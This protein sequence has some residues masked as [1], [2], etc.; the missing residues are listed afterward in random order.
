MQVNDE[1]RYELCGFVAELVGNE[2]S[3]SL[4]DPVVIHQAQKCVAPEPGW[5][6][7][8]LR[9]VSR[10]DEDFVEWLPRNSKVWI[11]EGQSVWIAGRN[12]YADLGSSK[13]AAYQFDLDKWEIYKR[14]L[15]WTTGSKRDFERFQSRIARSAEEALAQLLFDP[16]EKVAGFVEDVFRVYT[17]LSVQDSL[18][19]FVWEGLFY[20]ETRAHRD[21]SLAARLAVR[22]GFVDSIDAFDVQV[23]HLRE[24]LRLPRL[25]ESDPVASNS[26]L[27]SAASYL[28][29][30]LDAQHT[31]RHAFEL[32]DSVWADQEFNIDLRRLGYSGEGLKSGKLE[33]EV[34]LRQ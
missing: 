9:R 29:A 14:G 21:Y 23:Q 31:G 15:R 34:R 28:Q 33:D 6:V 20:F 16:F 1:Q 4:G 32:E 30:F 13:L 19:R 26:D 12:F 25:S 5:N 11:G 8:S 2:G 10:H 17:A 24:W 18:E 27:W 22:E 7:N 3:L